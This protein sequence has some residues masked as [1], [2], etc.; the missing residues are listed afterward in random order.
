MD[1]R[2]GCCGGSAISGQQ[3]TYP[4]KPDDLQKQ[5][6][7]LKQQYDATTRDLQQRI[8]ALEQEIQKQKQEQ[9]QKEASEKA[10]EGTVSAVELAAQQAAKKAVLGES[11]QV[12]GKVS[13][14]DCL[15]NRRMTC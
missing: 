10:K 7:Q 12:G 15:R 6:E 2:A 1:C 5:L 11:D 3:H 4:P 14:P 8:A 13:G 9:K